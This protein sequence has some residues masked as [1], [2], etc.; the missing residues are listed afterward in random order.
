[1]LIID[2]F[3]LDGELL[4]GILRLEIF[5]S[6]CETLDGILLMFDIFLSGGEVLDKKLLLEMLVLGGELNYGIL[7]SVIFSACRVIDGGLLIL[8]MFISDGG[9]YV[10]EEVSSKLAL[11]FSNSQGI[12][13]EDGRFLQTVWFENIVGTALD[14]NLFLSLPPLIQPEKT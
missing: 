1:M 2:I 9:L 11:R 10:T 12:G 6:G 14:F 7:I 4:N 8:E 5:G 3:N 13:S